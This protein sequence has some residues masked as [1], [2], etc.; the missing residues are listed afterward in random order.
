MRDPLSIAQIFL[1]GA[2]SGIAIGSEALIGLFIVLII[3]GVFFG[4]YC[5]YV[6][7]MNMITDLANFLRWMFWFNTNKKNKY[8]KKE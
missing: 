8:N 2:I 4:G 6:C 1:Y 5:S 3:Y 7:P